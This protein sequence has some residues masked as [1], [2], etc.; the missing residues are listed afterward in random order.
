MKLT[1]EKVLSSSTLPKTI[2]M[3]NSTS[4][5]YFKNA[6]TVMA[7]ET[8]LLHNLV[9]QSKVTIKWCVQHTMVYKKK[10]FVQLVK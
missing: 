9:V 2:I 6:L 7:F 10:N 4:F 5:K 8:K 3:V 1:M